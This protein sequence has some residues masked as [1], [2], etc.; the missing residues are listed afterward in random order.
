MVG[1]GSRLPWKKH[2]IR[3]HIKITNQ[4]SLRRL[5]CFS[6]WDTMT[7]ASLAAAADEIS[8]L[9]QNLNHGSCGVPFAPSAAA[10]E[11]AVTRDG[12]LASSPASDP[13]NTLGVTQG[14]HPRVTPF[15]LPTIT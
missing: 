6:C 9:A 1:E 5:T 3:N 7:A 8:P 12:T 10:G 11:V 15:F 13:C 4:Q 14:V 2:Q